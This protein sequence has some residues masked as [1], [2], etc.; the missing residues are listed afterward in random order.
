MT[1]SSSSLTLSV[2][3]PGTVVE[4]EGKA[5]SGTADMVIKRKNELM[6]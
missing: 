1:T 4:T 6:G 3:G 2:A 5:G